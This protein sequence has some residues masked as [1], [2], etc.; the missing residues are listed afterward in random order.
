MKKIVSAGDRVY[1]KYFD[2]TYF[3]ERAREAGAAFV[4]FR[5]LDDA[6][7]VAEIADADAL[8]V[9]DRPIT[10]AHLAAMDRCRIIQALEVGTD[11]IDVEAA[12][13]KGIVV[14]NVPAYCTDEVATHAIML[15]LA[16]SRKLKDLMAETGAGGWNY[17]AGEP[18]Y[19]VAGRTLGLVGFGRIGRRVVPKA[20][21]LGMEVAAYDPYLSDDIFAMAGVRRVYELPELLEQADFVSLHVPLTGETREMI[22]APELGLMKHEAFLINTC[23]GMVVDEGALVSALDAGTIAGAALDVVQ[24]EP[25]E[26]DR[27]ILRHPRAVVTP[28]AAWFSQE[29]LQR[30]KDQGMDEVVRVL[31]GERSRFAVN[32]QVYFRRG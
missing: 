27:P 28:H 2:L 26:A 24:R 19:H 32:P 15:L 18:V 7:F 12:T 4:P 9:I 16:A 31:R 21:G 29:S 8:V 5:S 30:V 11:F 6:A 13:E 17:K 10:A 1:L 25:P 20:V 3:H 22:G 14:A 23:R